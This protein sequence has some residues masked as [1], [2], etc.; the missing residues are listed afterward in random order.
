VNLYYVVTYNWAGNEYSRFIVTAESRD[1][2]ADKAIDQTW[3]TQRLHE[4]HLIRED[5]DFEHLQQL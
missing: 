1:F 5:V 2:A 3:P 4:I